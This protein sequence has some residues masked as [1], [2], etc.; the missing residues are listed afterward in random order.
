MSDFIKKSVRSA[1]EWNFNFNRVRKEER[2]ACFDLQTNVFYILVMLIFNIF[3]CLLH[4]IP[5]L[6][7]EDHSLS[8]G[9][10][11]K[12]G[13][14]FY[15]SELLSGGPYSWTISRILSHVGTGEIV[16]LHLIGEGKMIYFSC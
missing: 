9:K 15:E 2:K 4:N 3:T 7:L 5:C 1:A 10:T 11:I 12:C 6:L 8:F 14:A 13:N 16:L